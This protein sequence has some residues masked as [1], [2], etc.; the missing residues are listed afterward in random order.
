[1]EPKKQI[2]L[3]LDRLTKAQREQLIYAHRNMAS[4]YIILPDSHQFIGVHCVDVPHL[5]IVCT[6]N[7]WSIGH[8]Q[9][10]QAAPT[11]GVARAI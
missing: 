1:M 8:I 3:I 10:N 6:Y 5:K 2:E 4:Q 11:N 7:D 9:Y